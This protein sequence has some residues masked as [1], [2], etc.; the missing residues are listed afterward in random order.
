MEKCLLLAGKKSLKPRKMFYWVFKNNFIASSVDSIYPLDEVEIQVGKAKVIEV[1][2]ETKLGYAQLG[3]QVYELTWE[4]KVGWHSKKVMTRK[5]FLQL[6][7]EEE[8]Q[9][10]KESPSPSNTVS[11]E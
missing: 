4:N 2:Y 5:E 3:N 7:D 9:S 10:I 6:T 1:N 11:L 8:E